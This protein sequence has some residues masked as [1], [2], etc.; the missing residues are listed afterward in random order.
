M[1]IHFGRQ[2]Y[3]FITASALLNLQRF[4]CTVNRTPERDS[5]SG[6][7]SF[8]FRLNDPAFLHLDLRR[9]ILDLDRS[10]LPMFAAD[11][12]LWS[13]GIVLKLQTV[14]SVRPQG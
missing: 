8:K 12:I 5:I 9:W 7:A 3:I 10:K 14:T 13:Y 1:A 4:F 2:V 6:R 11:P